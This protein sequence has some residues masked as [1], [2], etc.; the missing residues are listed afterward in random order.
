[1][2]ARTRVKEAKE[3][4]VTEQS[5]TP[6][7]DSGW[8]SVPVIERLEW[9]LEQ[10]VTN[11]G[12]QYE[13]GWTNYPLHETVTAALAELRAAQAEL[14]R[15]RGPS[16][17]ADELERMRQEANDNPDT[18]RIEELNYVLE[19]AIAVVR[20]RDSELARLRKPN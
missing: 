13:G 4:A 3:Q 15:L 6:K 12:I 1:V 10:P 8:R 19:D 17:T 2:V 7:T 18:V 11:F 9:L 20:Q 5:E 14:A 16:E